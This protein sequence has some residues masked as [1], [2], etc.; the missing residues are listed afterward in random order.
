[1]DEKRITITKQD[2][3]KLFQ[4]VEMVGTGS[5]GEVF[6][7]RSVATGEL[8]AL[9]II[10]MEPGEDLDE[11]L[12]EVNFLQ[13][14]SHHN[15]VSYG[16]CYLK[17][18]AG[19]KGGKQIWI[20]M[21]YC[22]GGSVE[23]IYKA[24]RTP[25]LEKE[26]A[27]I[28]RESLAGLAFL[29]SVRKLHRDIKSGNILLTEMGAVKLADFGVST[30]LTKTFSK[31]NTFIGTP[32]WM[33][34][35]VITA[36]Q[37]NTSYDYKADVWSLG[38]TTVEMAEC[39]PP[40]FDMHPM[41]VLFMIPKSPPPTLKDPQ[42]SPLIRSFLV[43]CLKKNPDERPTAEDLLKHPFCTSNPRG[44]AILIELIERARSSKQSRKSTNG[45]KSIMSQFQD[46]DEEEEAQ[47]DEAASTT[48]TDHDDSASQYGATM[49]G[50]AATS[51]SESESNT[52][53]GRDRQDSDMSTVSS[54][55]GS[56]VIND[57]VSSMGTLRPAFVKAMRESSMGS[58]E[59][60]DRDIRAAT[61]RP[62]AVAVNS[63]P[64]ELV[65]EDQ[66]PV[67]SPSTPSALGVLAAVSASALNSNR[68]SSTH[69]PAFESPVE[70][71]VSGSGISPVSVQSLQSSHV[72]SVASPARA[73][74]PQKLVFKAAR[75]CRLAR[76][77]LCAQYVGDLLLIGLEQGL[78]GYEHT[79]SQILGAPKMIP[80]SHRRYQQLDLVDEIGELISLSGK[81]DSLCLHDI[82]NLDKHKVKK[83][84][85][86]ETNTR[87]LKEAKDCDLYEI[88]KVKTDVYLCTSK[89]KH[90]LILKWAPQPLFKFMKCREVSMDSKPLSI[91]IA[92]GSK[93]TKMF[94]GHPKGAFRAID[95][96]TGATE[97]IPAQENSGKPVKV[98]EIGNGF[99]VL[100]Y[101]NYGVQVSID[102]L[103]EEV[104][105]FTW[106]MGP[107]TF[108]TKLY[109]H[110][111]NSADN[112]TMSQTSLSPS[113][114]PQFNTLLVAGSLTSV[115]IWSMETG[116][117]VHIF[118][119][120]KDRIKKLSYLFVKSGYKLFILADEEKDGA[121]C[122]SII[123]VFQDG[124]G[125]DFASL[126]DSN[127]IGTSMSSMGSLSTMNK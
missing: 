116:K 44:S 11:V 71:V 8:V 15:I 39:S 102:N 127:T 53:V 27:V 45:A 110:A 24:L 111:S 12:N 73:H 58:E 105:R 108:A 60:E 119:T 40:M 79:E 51:S 10:K 120:K 92:E 100:C 88:S 80:L 16:G 42:W 33:A 66:T 107:L 41:R 38:I 1:M 98:I 47:D 93:G 81:H 22:G 75:L 72:G 126:Q 123:T 97:E 90:I 85:E 89:G 77:V 43:D 61:L 34:P 59:D 65:H 82:Q 9:K 2:P 36:E 69:E 29:H 21:E 94:V 99:V 50:R 23:S 114:T 6:K 64:Q 103:T 48:T 68:S 46:S 52:I 5:Y 87:K 32:Y 37:Q 113:I 35:E 122:S 121:K 112:V 17:K 101:E 109:V 31:R 96:V 115:D 28:I 76:N 83:K 7:A 62:N 118:E 55:A 56:V 26:I 14:C 25:L 20:A 95:I 13:S 18:S 54:I 84:F 30:Q 104:R 74:P 49:K 86:A 63:R 19:L 67:G 106:R 117:I 4:I 78:F 91:D 57:D 70:S 3:E 125:R 124:A